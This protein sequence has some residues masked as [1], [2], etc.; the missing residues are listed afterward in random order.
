MGFA[1]RAS[2]RNGSFLGFVRAA[3]EE[4]GGFFAVAR[5]VNLLRG[6]FLI[7]SRAANSQ[8]GSFFTLCIVCKLLAR[9]LFH[10][11]HGMQTSSEGA[12]FKRG[13][14]YN[15]ESRRKSGFSLFYLFKKGWK[16][17]GFSLE[18]GC[19]TCVAYEDVNVATGDVCDV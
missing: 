5:A 16:S 19:F 6:S 14:S 1:G 18:C 8:Q 10:S 17:W 11:L 4:K 7:V 13:G 12:F 2:G 15:S 3:S 9:V